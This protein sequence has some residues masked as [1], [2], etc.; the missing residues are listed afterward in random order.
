MKLNQFSALHFFA[1]DLYEEFGRRWDANSVSQVCAA[2]RRPIISRYQLSMKF[3]NMVHV[4]FS[5][6]FANLFWIEKL[7][8]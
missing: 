6:I 1:N 7:N 3:G 4:K 2:L 8:I 5:L